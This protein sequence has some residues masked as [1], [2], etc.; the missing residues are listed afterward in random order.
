MYSYKNGV[1]VGNV[2]TAGAFDATET[3]GNTV[4]GTIV[5]TAVVG[6]QAFVGTIYLIKVYNK[7]F[8]AQEVLQNYNATKTRFGLT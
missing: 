5:G 2:T 1:L 8:T 6:Q 4:I 3:N 7:F